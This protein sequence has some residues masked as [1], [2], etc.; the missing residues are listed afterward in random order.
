MPP[1]T[2][3]VF[4]I[5]KDQWPSFKKLVRESYELV[6]NDVRI[7]SYVTSFFSAGLSLSLDNVHHKFIFEYREETWDDRKL[8]NLILDGLQNITWNRKT[9]GIII[10]EIDE[11][12]VEVDSVFGT[13]FA[14]DTNEKIKQEFLKKGE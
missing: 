7:K 2:K 3:G 12:N 8:L 1:S 6:Y 10:R 4:Y 13:K 14:K 9:G 11:K 5:P